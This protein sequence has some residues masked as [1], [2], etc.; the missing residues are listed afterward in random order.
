VSKY[1]VLQIPA[2]DSSKSASPPIGGAIDKYWLDLPNLGRFLLKADLRGAW[3]E[4]VTATLA[5]RIGLPVAGY[6]LAERTDGLKMIASPNFLIDFA[7]EI[8]GE[9]L[10]VN[11]LGENYLYTPDAIFAVV[12]NLGASLPTNYEPPATVTTA[13]DLL[14]GYLM[15]DSWIGNID[16]H[17]RNWGIQQTLDGRIELL[18]VFDHGLSLGVRMPE[19]KL[20]LDI[21]GFS[22]DCR[23]SIQGE[24]GGALT[25]DGLASRLL[26]MKPAVASSWIE[27]IATIDRVT[28]EEIVE[29]VPEGWVDDIRKKFAID[30][31]DTSRD[32]LITLASS[33]ELT[34]SSEFTT[35]EPPQR[36]SNPGA[37]IN[38]NQPKPRRSPG[39]SL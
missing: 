6:E 38:E 23:S 35:P 18:P 9:E 2:N 30:F 33:R 36:F 7:L 5:D 22:G 15:F 14:A 25:M 11:A 13:S 17:S 20:P 27:R 8:P 31:L 10:L 1:P 3:V 34:L 26:E 39:L 21:A 12:D 4:K 16:R 32:R 19:D 37:N 28:I 29:R 24:V